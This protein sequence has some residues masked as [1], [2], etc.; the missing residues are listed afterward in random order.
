M[1]DPGGQVRNRFDFG[2]TPSWNTASSHSNTTTSQDSTFTTLPG[3]YIRDEPVRVVPPPVV[4]EPVEHS[5]PPPP[6]PTSPNVEK[7]CRICLCGAEDGK[8]SL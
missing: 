7:T 2:A 4:P 5:P 1:T 3:A 6:N 8:N